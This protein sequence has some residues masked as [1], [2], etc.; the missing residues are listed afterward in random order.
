M[1]QNGKLHLN[2]GRRRQ[3]F[4]RAFVAGLGSPALVFHAGSA[5]PPLVKVL[6]E[7]SPQLRVQ[8]ARALVRE[9]AERCLGKRYAQA[10]LTEGSPL[11]MR[12]SSAGVHSA[13]SASPSEDPESRHGG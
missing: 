12:E 3:V 11:P 13:A 1:T 6:T 7:T 8:R 9:A 10:L 2:R 4:A 5:L